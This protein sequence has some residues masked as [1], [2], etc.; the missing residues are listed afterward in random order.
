MAIR[1]IL[2]Y[3]DKRLR[4]PAE[5]VTE[6]DDALQAL[7]VSNVE[8]VLPFGPLAGAELV[9]TQSGMRGRLAAI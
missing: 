1:P 9:A 7:A 6:F 3:P 5:P 4:T 2:H 8:A